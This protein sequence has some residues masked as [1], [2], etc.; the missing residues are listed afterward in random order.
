M[1]VLLI[2]FRCCGKTSAGRF[3][4]REMGLQFFDTDEVIVKEENKSIVRIFETEGEDSFRK[5]ERT[6]MRRL[7]DKKN[8]VIALGGGAVQHSEELD[9]LKKN[10]VC[11]WLKAEVHTISE[12][13]SLN[14]KSSEIGKCC[15]WNLYVSDFQYLCC[16]FGNLRFWLHHN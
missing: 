11:V 15:Y 13:M 2:G 1:N 4:A 14:S 3:L 7:V 8:S 9:D 5:K 12:R 6:L 10:A 16:C